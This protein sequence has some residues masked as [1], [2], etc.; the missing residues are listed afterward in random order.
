MSI[1]LFSHLLNVLVAG[2]FGV[3]LLLNAPSMTTVY[4]AATPAR[5]ILASIYLSIAAA[6]VCALLFP[7]YSIAIATVLFPLQIL[8]KLST[9]LTVGSI[10]HPVVVSNLLISVVHAISLF[11]IFR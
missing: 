5:G 6:S 7:A 2:G 3:L 8:Y 11:V 4:G 9:V 10:M 1:I